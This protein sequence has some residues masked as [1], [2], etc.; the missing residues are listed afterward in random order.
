M[1]ASIFISSGV[2][3]LR[4][5]DSKVGR[6]EPFMKKLSGVLTI[7][8][9]AGQAVRLNGAVQVGAGA[10]MA[11]GRLPRLGAAALAGSLV[12]TTVAAHPFWEEA[13]PAVRKEQRILFLKNV[14]LLGG[15]ILAMFDWEG[16]PSPGWRAR[17][18]ARR[19][20]RKIGR[21]KVLHLTGGSHRAG[22]SA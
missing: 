5:P 4:D 16:T 1:L 13:D 12:P 19:A 17:R 18:G 11:L 14:G 6:A 20:A 7:P 2:E 9:D 15:L 10:L 22:G 8:C 3:A 21:S